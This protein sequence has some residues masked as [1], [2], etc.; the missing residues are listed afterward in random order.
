MDRLLLALRIC[1]VAFNFQFI[2]TATEKGKKRRLD[3]SGTLP[4]PRH[5][6]SN[7]HLFLVWV[8]TGGPKRKATILHLQLFQFLLSA[9]EFMLLLCNLE[10]ELIMK[11]VNRSQD[12]ILRGITLKRLCSG[13]EGIPCMKGNASYC[14]YYWSRDRLNPITVGKMHLSHLVFLITL[15]LRFSICI[16]VFIRFKET[17]SETL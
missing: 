2:F 3:S 6:G 9:S 15:N 11:R 13:I 10:A 7:L 17:S 8:L 5:V 14:I 1:V 4:G 12:P 16:S